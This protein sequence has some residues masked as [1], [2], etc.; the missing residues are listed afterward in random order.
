MH[1]LKAVDFQISRGEIVGLL[2]ENAEG[3]STLM[4]VLYGAYQPDS[5]QITLDGK[6]I[7][8]ANPRA[9]MEQGIGMV[10][11]EQS[12][13]ANLSVMENTFLGSEQHFVPFGVINWKAMADDA[14]HQLAKVKLEIDPTTVTSA[15]SFAQRQLVELAKVLTL[16]E[17]VQRNL[18]ILLHE[19]TSVLS[20]DEVKLQF[21]LVR[22]L[23]TRAS[24]VFVGR[25][26]MT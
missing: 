4:K 26:S 12:L 9:A 16:E 10:C 21:K 5:G 14:R 8:F 18:L 23:R 17:R 24:L 7:R 11:Q 2:G 1:A 3:K 19:P 20:E 15:L 25:M 6:S 13:I 22:E